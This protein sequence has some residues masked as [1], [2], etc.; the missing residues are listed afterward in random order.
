MTTRIFLL[1]NS[2]YLKDDV[3]A[4]DGRDRDTVGFN[5]VK[6]IHVDRD[7]SFFGT[8]VLIGLQDSKT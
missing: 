1:G 6:N 2:I 8:L 5:L 3:C 4:I 7:P